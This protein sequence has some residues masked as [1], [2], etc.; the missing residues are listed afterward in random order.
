MRPL[1]SFIHVLVPGVRRLDY[2]LSRTVTKTTPASVT[3]A[4]LAVAMNAFTISQP[5]ISSNGL[6]FIHDDKHVTYSDQPNQ[7]L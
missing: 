2:C 5:C 6:N 3:P 1:E 4:A 7:Y